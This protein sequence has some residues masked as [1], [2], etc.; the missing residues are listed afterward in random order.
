VSTIKPSN[1][2]LLLRAAW[3]NRD[4]VSYLVRQLLQTDTRRFGALRKFVPSARRSDWRLI[5]AGQ[6]VQVMKR[7]ASGGEIVGF[8]TEA[9][10]S[11]DRSLAGLLG[12]S[13]GASSAPSTMLEVLLAC[14]PE[15]ETRWGDGARSMMPSYGSMLNADP[16]LLQDVLARTDASLRLTSDSS[17]AAG[18]S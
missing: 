13:P 15:R 5:T 16:Q 8:G 14:F 18:R 7:T 10:I 2:G 3:D 4:L 11:R 17:G 12:S 9:V 6:R 1:V